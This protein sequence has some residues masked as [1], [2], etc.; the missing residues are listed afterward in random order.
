[1]RLRTALVS[2][3]F[4]NV[5][6]H[7]LITIIA[8]AELMCQDQLVIS[9]RSRTFLRPPM[10]AERTFVASAMM[11]GGAEFFGESPKKVSCR[12]SVMR[13]QQS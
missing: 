3:L 4:K 12:E 11:G 9:W 1:M 2:A 5:Q 7:P 10:G 6:C 8:S 13:E